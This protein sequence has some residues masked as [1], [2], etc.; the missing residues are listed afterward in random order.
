MA[1]KQGYTFSHLLVL[2]K[3]PTNR[4]SP[5]SGG[6]TDRE[7]QVI[8]S[9]IMPHKEKLY[10]NLCFS[11]KHL[12]AF[13]LEMQCLVFFSILFMFSSFNTKRMY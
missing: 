13:Y 2:T 11:L 4:N 7:S 3:H 10:V 6:T 5:G 1:I 8:I 12:K 9:N